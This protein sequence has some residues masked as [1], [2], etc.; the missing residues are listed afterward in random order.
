MQRIIRAVKLNDIF[1]L[2]RQ[3][4]RIRLPIPKIRQR[5]LGLLIPD[6]SPHGA[7]VLRPRGLY[8]AY[9]SVAT[10]EVRLG[11][12][13]PAQTN[14]VGIWLIRGGGVR[15][16]SGAYPLGFMAQLTAAGYGGALGGGICAC[17]GDLAVGGVHIWSPYRRVVSKYLRGTP[18][19]CFVSFE[20]SA[21]AVC[22]VGCLYLCFERVLFYLSPHRRAYGYGSRKRAGR[23]KLSKQ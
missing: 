8:A 3:R 6:S 12:V 22:E 11:R 13:C 5:L 21:A 2:R 14:R 19:A 7:A 10:L 1:L 15:G 18:L 9:R 16:V 17:G 4:R 20:R 23:K